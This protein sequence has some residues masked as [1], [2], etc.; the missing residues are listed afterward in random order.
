VVCGEGQLARPL[1]ARLAALGARDRAELR[2]YVAIDGG[3]RELYRASHAFL[4]VSWTEGVPQVLFE[5]FAAGLPVVATAVG[6]VAEAVGDA[7]L[8][9]P[10]GDA[11][12]AA[13]ALAR[14]AGDADLR[15]RLVDAGLALAREHTIESE[16]AHVLE[17]LSVA[18]G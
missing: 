7:A 9:V 5:A 4:H 17:F 15:A 12:A 3:L 11:D 2:G 6:G 14:I 1:E 16:T 18:G 13:H 8:L 10:P